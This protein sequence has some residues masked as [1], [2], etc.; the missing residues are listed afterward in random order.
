M[1]PRSA[2]SPP[3]AAAGSK[4]GVP[5]NVKVKL[6]SYKKVGFLGAMERMVVRCA[7]VRGA[8]LRV[9]LLFGIL[10]PLIWVVTRV[11]FIAG[12]GFRTAI[13]EAVSGDEPHYMMVVNSLLFHHLLELQEDYRQVAMGGFEAGIRCR[14]ALLDHHTILVN[15]RTGHHALWL[16]VN[17]VIRQ[18]ASRRFPAGRSYIEY[19]NPEF[20]PSADVYEVSAHPVAFPALLAL[21]L[22]PLHPTITDVEPDVG[23]VL[24]LISWFGTLATYFLARRSGMKRRQA[25]LAVLLLVVASPWLPYSRSYYAESTI[26]LSLTLAMWALTAERP[27]LAAL[28]AAGASF[29]KPTFAVVGAG[30]VLEEIRERRW[31]AAAKM[32]L[33]L[34]L[35]GLATFA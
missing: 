21:T 32:G 30:F 34:S 18:A 8:N 5:F 11:D 24:A 33:V 4:T 23:F 9:A 26:G 10:L 17:K 3:I 28:A 35:C 13:P 14:G 15:K 29:L 12:I 22:A 20:A 19:T 6:I 1:Q 7:G 31:Q 25:T 27:A 2:N 16:S